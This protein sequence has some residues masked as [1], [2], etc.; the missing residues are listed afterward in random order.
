MHER[1]AAKNR[2]EISISQ[3][4]D[5]QR[6]HLSGGYLEPA[7]LQGQAW[8]TPPAMG[9]LGVSVLLDG[10]MPENEVLVCRKI[11]SLRPV[12]HRD[13]WF[14]STDKGI[15]CA[16]LLLRSLGQPKTIWLS[17]HKTVLFVRSHLPL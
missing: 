16:S 10:P 4:A 1:H 7:V 17:L 14:Q 6:S 8:T 13:L 15:P 3:P 5:A 9:I 11:F 2:C 12:M